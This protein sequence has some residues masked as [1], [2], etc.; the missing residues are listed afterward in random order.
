MKFLKRNRRGEVYPISVAAVLRALTRAK[1]PH[2]MFGVL[3]SG[4][5]VQLDDGFRYRR[6]GDG[7]LGWCEQCFRHPC[8]CGH[9]GR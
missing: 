8:C 6:A 2:K 4:V 5:E 9:E 3:Q 7:A 1:L